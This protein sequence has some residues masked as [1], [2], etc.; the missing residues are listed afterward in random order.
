MN[1]II[2]IMEVRDTGNY[3][4]EAMVIGY[5]KLLAD[6]NT[7]VVDAIC[8]N[9]EN[10]NGAEIILKISLHVLYNVLCRYEMALPAQIDRIVYINSD[11]HGTL[12]I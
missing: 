12:E 11:I 10:N 7:T 5:D 4:I 8:T 6:P 3:F 9:I 1:I 2:N